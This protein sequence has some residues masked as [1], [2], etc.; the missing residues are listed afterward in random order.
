MTSSVE[1]LYEKFLN[2]PDIV[3][4]TTKSREEVA[5]G[6][7]K[8][9]FIQ[10]MNNHKALSLA[11]SGPV[12]D[13]FSFLRYR[14]VFKS[15]FSAHGFHPAERDA[16][17]NIISPRQHYMQEYRKA[18]ITHEE[19]VQSLKDEY[20][21]LLANRRQDLGGGAFPYTFDQLLADP[22]KHHERLKEAIIPDSQQLLF[23]PGQSGETTPALR[24]MELGLEPEEDEE[25]KTGRQKEL[26]AQA[27]A[28]L[29]GGDDE[30]GTAT[31]RQ[32]HRSLRGD[33]ATALMG[34]ANIEPG[35]GADK[36]AM[37]LL[38]ERAGNNRTAQNHVGELSG[39]FAEINRLQSV[40][41]NP[42][43]TRGRKETENQSALRGFD[44][45]EQEYKQSIGLKSADKLSSDQEETLSQIEGS[46]PYMEK[47]RIEELQRL[48]ESIKRIDTGHSDFSHAT[49]ADGSIRT[50]DTTENN[51]YSPVQ[52]WHMFTRSGSSDGAKLQAE[53]KRR[54]DFGIHH[55]QHEEISSLIRQVAEDNDITLNTPPD[56]IEQN[57]AAWHE[58]HP[59]GHTK[60]T[61]VK[62][63]GEKDPEDMEM[64]EL[65]DYLITHH[66]D[67]GPEGLQ[68]IFDMIDADTTGKYQKKEMESLKAAITPRFLT[69]EQ[70]LEQTEQARTARPTSDAPWIGDPNQAEMSDREANRMVGDFKRHPET[71]RPSKAANLEE[72]RQQQLERR[73]RAITEVLDGQGN[74]L[75][76]GT[77]LTDEQGNAL[78]RRTRMETEQEAIRRGP[79]R[80]VAAGETY[81]PEL[82][83]GMDRAGQVGSGWPDRVPTPRV[84]G[85]EHIGS[86]L[87]GGWRAEGVDYEGG[88]PLYPGE[89]EIRLYSKDLTD[90]YLGK[91]PS[92]SRRNSRGQP[93]TAANTG[94]QGGRVG[95][96]QIMSYLIALGV[97]LQDLTRPNDKGKPV[98]SLYSMEQGMKLHGFLND[99]DTLQ[100]GRGGEV[101][102]GGASEGMGGQSRSQVPLSR[103]TMYL[104]SEG[105]EDEAQKGVNHYPRILPGRGPGEGTQGAQ[106]REGG[107]GHP[108]Y[109]KRQALFA[110]FDAHATDEQ[111]ALLKRVGGGMQR[112]T[113]QEL[114][115]GIMHLLDGGPDLSGAGGPDR[116]AWLEAMGQDGRQFD[117]D[118][119]SG[120]IK[121]KDGNVIGTPME[122]PYE[123]WGF[124]NQGGDRFYNNN[125]QRE[126]IPATEKRP[127]HYAVPATQQGKGG[128]KPMPRSTAPPGFPLSVTDFDFTL[129]RS[130]WDANQRRVYK[131]DVEPLE[132][133]KHKAQHERA[134]L[135]GEPTF[136]HDSAGGARYFNQLVDQVVKDNPNKPTV[137]QAGE[138]DYI[139]HHQIPNMPQLEPELGPG[140]ALG[141]TGK[142]AE[143]P[144]RSEADLREVARFEAN[145][146]AILDAHPDSKEFFRQKII[147]EFNDDHRGLIEDSGSEL[148]Q[149]QLW[150][151]S[152]TV[153]DKPIKL[154]WSDIARWFQHKKD[155]DGNPYIRNPQVP[156]EYEDLYPE[157]HHGVT[158]GSRLPYVEGE[159]LPRSS[160]LPRR[161]ED[162]SPTT[163]DPVV[164]PPTPEPTGGG[165]SA[166]E[167]LLRQRQPA[168]APETP[169]PAV[170]ALVDRQRR[171]AIGGANV[172]NLNGVEDVRRAESRGEGVDILRKA[173]NQHYGNPFTYRG[174]TRAEVELPTVEEATQAYDDWLHGRKYSNVK[175]EQRQWILDQI[176]NGALNNK[177]L[178]Y[179]TSEHAD[180]GID[181]HADVLARFINEAKGQPEGA[182]APPPDRIDVPR[183]QGQQSAQPEDRTEALLRQRGAAPPEG[184][185][186]VERES[187]MT[188]ELVRA[189]P[190]KIYLFGDNDERRGTG[191]Q[192]QIRNENNV[193]GIRTKAAPHTGD[194]AY[195]TPEGHEENIAKIDEDFKAAID[196]ARAENKTIVIPTNGFGGG[197]S[198]LDEKS[199][200]TFAHINKRI[201]EFESGNFSVSPVAGQPAAANP[202]DYTN[203][204]GGA[205][206]GDTL[207]DAIGKE[208]GITNH[209][210]YYQ[211]RPTS[212]GNT[213]ISQAEADEA[214]PHLRQAAATMGRPFSERSSY[215]NLLKR[216]WQQVKNADGIYAATTINKGSKG[217]KPTPNVADGGT[218]WAIHMAIH[219]GKP[220]HVFE[221]RDRKWYTWNRDQNQ[222]V[223]EGTPTLTKNYAGIGSRELHKPGT[224][225][226]AS[227]LSQ[228]DIDAAKSAIREVHE[229]T[230]RS[231]PRRG[232]R[233]YGGGMTGGAGGRMFGRADNMA[234]TLHDILG[235]RDGTT[236][237]Q[238]KHRSEP[239][240]EDDIE[241]VLAMFHGGSIA[242]FM[243]ST[244][245]PDWFPPQDID[246]YKSQFSLGEDLDAEDINE[247]HGRIKHLRDAVKDNFGPRPSKS[248]YL[249]MMEHILEKLRNHPSY[250]SNHQVHSDLAAF[251]HRRDNDPYHW[252]HEPRVPKHYEQFKEQFP[253]TVP[254][255]A[256]ATPTGGEVENQ[257]PPFK[258]MESPD[259]NHPNMPGNWQK[260]HFTAPEG[261]EYSGAAN[262]TEALRQ[263]HLD[264]KAQQRDAN[265]DI[266]GA[267]LQ[268]MDTPGQ[269]LSS[270][271]D[272]QDQQPIHFNTSPRRE[273]EHYGSPF[274]YK[275]ASDEAHQNAHIILPTADDAAQ[276][277]E[278]WLHGDFPVAKAGWYGGAH[279]FAKRNDRTGVQGAPD[280]QHMI[281]ELHTLATS[282]RKRAIARG[283]SLEDWYKRKFPEGFDVGDFIDPN[284]VG[285]KNE[286][287]LEFI[288]L[289]DVAPD[290]RKWVLEQIAAGK[291]N[292]KTLLHLPEGTKDAEVLQHYVNIHK[293]VPAYRG[294][295]NR[296]SGGSPNVLEYEKLTQQQ[297]DAVMDAMEGGDPEPEEL[298]D[299]DEAAP[300]VPE[301]AAAPVIPSSDRHRVDVSRARRDLN[302]AYMQLD[303][304][305]HDHKAAAGASGEEIYD[306]EGNYKEPNNEDE[307]RILTSMRRVQ[308]IR[309]KDVQEKLQK[310]RDLNG[311][312]GT[313]KD[314]LANRLA[315]PMGSR[316]SSEGDVS[317]I[318]AGTPE[319]PHVDSRMPTGEPEAAPKGISMP[320]P[321]TMERLRP[322]AIQIGDATRRVA[323][324]AEQPA[325]E[326]APAEQPAA[327]EAPAGPALMSLRQLNEEHITHR[328]VREA[329]A[330]QKKDAD[331]NPGK[332]S[333]YHAKSK[334][335]FRKDDGTFEDGW[336]R[337]HLSRGMK[338]LALDNTDDDENPQPLI[339]LLGGAQRGDRN[340]QWK[341]TDIGEREIAPILSAMHK[342]H[343]TSLTDNG[344]DFHSGP[345]GPT[346]YDD[347]V[348]HTETFEKILGYWKQG[349][350]PT[351]FADEDMSEQHNRWEEFR[352][353]S[354][355]AAKQG[356]VPGPD[357]IIP[358]APDQP[359]EEAAQPAAADIPDGSDSPMP[360]E[361]EEDLSN[362]SKEEVTAKLRAAW[363]KMAATEKGLKE[364][365]LGVP[366]GLTDA[367][368]YDNEGNVIVTSPA[369][370]NWSISNLRKQL[371]TE[372]AEAKKWHGAAVHL[373]HFV[374]APNSYGPG[375]PGHPAIG[376]RAADLQQPERSTV[377]QTPHE[378]NTALDRGTPDPTPDPTAEAPRYGEPPEEGGRR[379]A[380][381][382]AVQPSGAGGG[383]SPPPKPSQDD[384]NEHSPGITV[385]NFG[386]GDIANVRGAE[387][388]EGDNPYHHVDRTGN[389]IIN[390]ELYDRMG[391]RKPVRALH[392]AA[393]KSQS[394]AGAAPI[395]NVMRP[396]H[397]QQSIMSLSTLV[398]TYGSPFTYP[399]EEYWGRDENHPGKAD[400]MRKKP[401]MKRNLIMLPDAAAAAQAYR[402]WLNYADTTVRSENGKVYYLGNMAGAK[403]T[404]ED[405]EEQYT[406]NTM[407]RNWITKQL[408]EG[409]LSGTVNARGDVIKQPS[410]LG[411]H[412]PDG[413]GTSESYAD[414]LAEIANERHVQAAIGTAWKQPPHLEIP[415]QQLSRLR[416]QLKE[417]W[418]TMDK[419][420]S[421]IKD[422]WS[423][424]PDVTRNS[425]VTDPNHPDSHSFTDMDSDVSPT[426]LLQTV[427]THQL[428]KGRGHVGPERD[429]NGK[430]IPLPLDAEGKPDYSSILYHKI[431]DEESPRLGEHVPWNFGDSVQKH[432]F[433]IGS[434]LHTQPVMD[435]VSFE[436]A[437]KRFR[438]LESAVEK[439]SQLSTELANRGETMLPSQMP[440]PGKAGSPEHPNKASRLKELPEAPT[441]P[442][443]GGP[444]EPPVV[445]PSPPAADQPE[446]GE[447]RKAVQG[448]ADAL[449]HRHQNLADQEEPTAEPAAEPPT[450]ADRL[451]T[452]GDRATNQA[453][454]GPPVP[455][456]PTGLVTHEEINS[457]VSPEDWSRTDKF[458]YAYAIVQRLIADD[459]LKN[460]AAE[461]Y[462]KA[463]TE[464]M[465]IHGIHKGEARG[466]DASRSLGEF[467][468]GSWSEDNDHQGVPFFPTLL[469]TLTKIERELVSHD[470]HDISIGELA[471]LGNVHGTNF[472]DVGTIKDG[473]ATTPGRVDM[474]HRNPNNAGMRPHPIDETLGHP[475]THNPSLVSDAD[476]VD[477]GHL[478]RLNRH[479]PQTPDQLQA[480]DGRLREQAIKDSES[481]H[482]V[483]RDESYG[484]FGRGGERRSPEQQAQQDRP[485]TT[486]ELNRSF[487]QNLPREEERQ[488]NSTGRRPGGGGRSGGGGGGFYPTPELKDHILAQAKK[489]NMSEQA[490]NDTLM[491]DGGWKVLHDH[492]LGE[493]KKA[494]TAQTKEGVADTAALHPDAV[495]PPLQEGDDPTQ[496]L[497]KLMI[498][499]HQLFGNGRRPDEKVRPAWANAYQTAI[500][501]GADI[502]RL[503]QESRDFPQHRDGDKVYGGEE[504]LR[505]VAQQ[506]MR[507][508]H[509][510]QEFHGIMN[511][512]EVL[513]QA[514]G[515]SAHYPHRED[516]IGHYGRHIGTNYNY[517]DDQGRVKRKRQHEVAANEEPDDTNPLI[518][519][520]PGQY[521]E[522][523]A[524]PPVAGLRAEQAD[525]Y[526]KLHGDYQYN[527]REKHM[528][529][530]DDL[531]P[532][533]SNEGLRRRKVELNKQLHPE[534]QT[535]VTTTDADGNRVTRPVEEDDY[536]QIANGSIPHQDMTPGILDH[537][538]F[539]TTHDE[540]HDP[541]TGTLTPGKRQLGIHVGEDWDGHW[542][543][544]RR[545][546]DEH[547]RLT[548]K[549]DKAT[550][551][552]A[553]HDEAINNVT[554]A[555]T[556]I[557][558][559]AA[560]WHS[561]RNGG[562]SSQSSFPDEAPKDKDGNHTMVDIPGIGMMHRQQLDGILKSIKPHQAV[563]LHNVTQNSDGTPNGAAHSI[564]EPDGVTGKEG[565]GA[566]VTHFGIFPSTPS[567]N[568]TET[569]AN[570]GT[571]DNWK[572]M[573]RDMG[574]RLHH[575]IRTGN[576]HLEH[577]N[578]ATMIHDIRGVLGQDHPLLQNHRIK[579]VLDKTKMSTPPQRTASIPDTSQSTSPPRVTSPSITTGPSKTGIKAPIHA[580]NKFFGK[581][582]ARAEGQ[583]PR[584][585]STDTISNQLKRGAYTIAS[586]VPGAM[587]VPEIKQGALNALDYHIQSMTPDD[588]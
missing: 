26:E 272:S 464:T 313:H 57:E 447:R 435:T 509:Q 257:L 355:E 451:E 25:E 552:T 52:Q 319:H 131:R 51:Y 203:H 562:V 19:L 323:A 215:V 298:R 76:Q 134:L 399:G 116:G 211:G 38:A 418:R 278:Q 182:A 175:P 543:E 573:G 374:G 106:S 325:A 140:E 147:K 547:T 541:D 428:G 366:S 513:K 17:G 1:T 296:P 179:Y 173:G 231:S 27:E 351:S 144:Q 544:M 329:E 280:R 336:D 434:L 322:E 142:P 115:A 308:G 151:E 122:G 163:G 274:S 538:L 149:G 30:G 368:I 469:G 526:R 456:L 127:E 463:L 383:W 259:Y 145:R 282:S 514:Y 478:D 299:R 222:F 373:N 479:K 496:Y 414:V 433:E 331:G 177:D 54:Y 570:N 33:P 586:K 452:L 199:P 583:N 581:H 188:S 295:E 252:N 349:L 362:V 575:A 326:E 557:D 10:S 474:F 429:E 268:S 471:H 410:I 369:G 358:D 507:N 485:P 363:S 261:R 197:F 201:Q 291:L 65:K 498:H 571:M 379:V 155:A 235:H 559:H 41:D 247:M 532:E 380:P 318:K 512:P 285:D 123:S 580:M 371:Q 461:N 505:S 531:T 536:D 472:S 431:T 579:K 214:I 508:A 441:A 555:Q 230:F 219:Q 248:H 244:L 546:G 523:T 254:E 87:A 486:D 221:P 453:A 15:E 7:A 226:P 28:L 68:S 279:P 352:R 80:V 436:G 487:N 392:D 162:A 216:N 289:G 566:V 78:P 350:L 491:F 574:N 489:R 198:K 388:I 238:L 501:A 96:R 403:R 61:P 16:E 530:G 375:S 138:P 132:I 45:V 338:D 401:K 270:A 56:S 378:L 185:L 251:E 66:E 114:R 234:D 423:S 525:A 301:E 9:R 311:F 243:D 212:L 494:L 578:D 345:D 480:F 139:S 309:I 334:W 287:G 415:G 83:R 108:A 458:K 584:Y 438:A 249:D 256:A 341:W 517:T 394:T 519:H 166:T 354:V 370:E 346:P 502:E 560:S 220:V 48:A 112:T 135:S 488:A 101:R 213:P 588:K 266:G 192:A 35:A 527:K 510:N 71:V 384:M 303:E 4:T 218:G 582:W 548:E 359:A 466:F 342:F 31:S 210:H 157:Y 445:P 381:E 98:W 396:Q 170:D 515:D 405:G 376:V 344:P 265:K 535:R 128:T 449:Q 40:L 92:A 481:Q 5:F 499:V 398:R 111:K 174:G 406:V 273:F 356:N 391:N 240:L 550:P 103:S 97:P 395:V 284:A 53:V 73:P 518:Q 382:P 37:E 417:A 143:M 136:A 529:Y 148:V 402:D 281:N 477:K 193:Y 448:L 36:N 107:P 357:T 258:H 565:K 228:A 195:W 253:P 69:D 63:V 189:N 242:E 549:L 100:Y 533:N 223:E 528:G 24:D 146:K 105:G 20:M 232:G 412:R 312:E 286:R 156:T 88:N 130:Q 372:V 191:G 55:G 389:V 187:N 118:S 404:G 328:L 180:A 200:E 416:S 534:H 93:Y 58:T 365:V 306:S 364:G 569:H 152:S 337:I 521:G 160:D 360:P 183:P 585:A 119:T 427:R 271:M 324:P 330:R 171:E 207:W 255:E 440:H 353:H 47:R 335:D 194:A 44:E 409:A 236:S 558:D 561:R 85:A 465:A 241:N 537:P 497:R 13:L 542:K 90:L 425:E 43:S 245:S 29:E 260:E 348:I 442:D 315:N 133:A 237:N 172:K 208:H 233:Q 95:F 181:S 184:G 104:H 572:I 125:N 520:N 393:Q 22:D 283:E 339:E 77:P 121:D 124:G 307:N 209:N 443:D 522:E 420:E 110:W 72:A 84:A 504:H 204:S 202:A 159:V 476:D 227:D 332:T 482:Q 82:G 229:K 206:G 158:E 46:R 190:D 23:R 196:R 483:Q 484:R 154:H 153:K 129:P 264:A 14:S 540:T 126:L 6:E 563:A 120:L 455:S 67:L 113:P 495:Q 60:T 446:N 164:R 12:E 459:R 62:H 551:N 297:R 246:D 310:V 556:N 205:I 460:T 288:N 400:F 176:Q 421:Q 117:W 50:H 577:Y 473:T 167:A 419:I 492:V 437:Y 454:G 343:H 516:I 457:S 225:F 304:H 186:R 293:G 317:F 386:D 263:H 74:P 18:P 567:T 70:R 224:K 470:D 385:R 413:E 500:D 141:K 267:E 444:T 468:D 94:T 390:S 59:E 137:N 217:Y 422:M 250:D 150:P 539:G 32:S 367:D 426:T 2:D 294:L 493:H 320:G 347:G 269:I 361:E 178:L 475:H 321:D 75:P 408:S 86:T 333:P 290:R 587:D 554:Q 169:Q 377:E 165:E 564:F 8:Q 276:A 576:P 327:E 503:N 568:A 397:S 168:A 292:N 506:D 239:R 439:A 42:I 275:D 89:N 387:T 316:R 545:L 91:V 300:S 81:S 411:Y 302:N 79:H 524:A 3:A 430:R 490:I 511:D 11:K 424:T 305:E 407:Q 64:E 161:G 462:L 277:Y 450:G 109:D 99:R 34:A 21:S 49:N 314:G 39:S 340:P 432:E 262:E 553:E 467:K 102:Q